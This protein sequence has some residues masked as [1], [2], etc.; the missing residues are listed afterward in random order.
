MCAVFVTI[1]VTQ[2]A[3][4]EYKSNLRKYQQELERLLK[5]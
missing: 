1:R 4:S 5:R 3:I 2:K